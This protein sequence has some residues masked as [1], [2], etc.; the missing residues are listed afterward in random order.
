[1]MLRVCDGFPHR[2]CRASVATWSPK[3]ERIHRHHPI[4]RRATTSHPTSEF[5]RQRGAAG[6]DR[7]LIRPIARRCRASN[8]TLA[9]T[10]TEDW[11]GN[12]TAW[13]SRSRK[14]SRAMG[15]AP[16]HRACSS[17][18]RH[19]APSSRKA[20][21]PRGD[22]G[23]RVASRVSPAAAARASDR[24]LAAARSLASLRRLALAAGAKRDFA[25]RRPAAHQHRN[26]LGNA[27]SRFCGS[28]K[29]S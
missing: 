21:A 16:A 13:A 23:Q 24:A 26:V 20:L 11:P 19:T 1:M 9:P 17:R 2:P 18:T 3:T 29:P 25:L 28:L 10:A 6:P 14:P 27:A 12:W 7:D 5:W 8:Q 22:S 15:S 4:S